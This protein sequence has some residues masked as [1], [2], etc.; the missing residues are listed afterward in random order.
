MELRGTIPIF[1][2]TGSGPILFK[3]FGINIE[4]AVLKN[5]NLISI[6]N[7]F[8]LL[9]V[10]VRIIYHSGNSYSIPL[11]SKNINMVS[12]SESGVRRGLNLLSS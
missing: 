9:T 10:K 6:T 5:G 1:W 12:S 4:R 7:P 3:L 11:R 2:E 8:H